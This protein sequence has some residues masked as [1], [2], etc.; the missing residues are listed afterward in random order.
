MSADETP[1]PLGKQLLAE[2]VGT[3]ALLCAVIGSGIM[4]QRISGGNDGVAL[5]ANT[6]AT[7]FALYVLIETLG[8]ISGAHFNP[9]VTL[10]LWSKGALAHVEPA[11][12]ATFFIAFQL[13]GAVAGA[14]LANAMFE[15]PVLHFSQHRARR[16]GPVAGGSG[17]HRWPAVHHPARTAGQSRRTG[18]L[19]YRRGLLVYRQH[20]VCQPSRRAGPHVQRHL[21]RHCTGQR[22]G[23]CAGAN[24]GRAAG[25]SLGPHTSPKNATPYDHHDLTTTPPAAPRATPWPLIR[26]SGVEPQ[27]IEYLKTPPDQ[28]AALQQLIQPPWAPARAPCCAKKGRRYA[29]LRPGQPRSGPM[30]QLLDVHAGAPHPDQP[31]HRGNALG[32]PPV[33]P[34][35]AGAGHPAP[36]AQQGAFTK[37]DGE[38]VV[39][40]KG[41]R[42]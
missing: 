23:L 38:A 19:L 20:L 41:Q 21:C 32:H 1:V 6:L 40:D 26:N 24:R 5:L 30:T 18:G 15:L 22:A 28:S 11:R 29:E 37:E 13:S 35:R 42:V 4:A 3:A 33:P 25:R 9:L 8:P 10:V 34:V 2:F 14:A 31:P 27:V 36:S 7:V 17:G 16:L 39:N 12:V